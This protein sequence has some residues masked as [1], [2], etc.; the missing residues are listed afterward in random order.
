MPT[1]DLHTLPKRPYRLSECRDSGTIGMGHPT[2]TLHRGGVLGAEGQKTA[3]L[4]GVQ[5]ILR[6][7]EVALGSSAVHRAIGTLAQR[8]WP[9]PFLGE[10][11]PTFF[12]ELGRETPKP[13]ECLNP[14]SLPRPGGAR[15]SSLGWARRQESLDHIAGYPK[16][17]PLGSRAALGPMILINASA[18]PI[19]PSFPKMCDMAWEHL[20]DGG[21]VSCQCTWEVS[22]IYSLQEGQVSWGD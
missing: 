4:Q 1:Q 17:S 11:H 10:R 13:L 19:T 18:V 6:G 2:Y 14:A 5:A 20:G 16:Y 22:P 7:R 12:P 9:A 15:L 21:A 8:C 3:S